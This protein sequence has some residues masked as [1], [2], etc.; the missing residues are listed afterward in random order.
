MQQ[1]IDHFSVD[2]EN[3]REA[4]NCYHCIRSFFGTTT[5]DPE[6]QRLIP[7]KKFVTKKSREPT[8]RNSEAFQIWPQKEEN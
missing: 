2:R 5:S 6:D 7:R 3:R 1:K 4:Q 8:S